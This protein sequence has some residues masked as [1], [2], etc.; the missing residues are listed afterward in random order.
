MRVIG[1]FLGAMLGAVLAG[2]AARAQCTGQQ[3]AI[4][5]QLNLACI[6]TDRN[7]VLDAADC[8]LRGFADVEQAD[9][10]VIADL[11]FVALQGSSPTKIRGCQAEQFVGDGNVDTSEGGGFV[12]FDNATTGPFF[13]SLLGAAVAALPVDVA[14][15][16]AEDAD[17]FFTLGAGRLVRDA[18]GTALDVTL[19]N[20]M[21]LRLGVSERRS[22]NTDLRCL[23]VPFPT[24]NGVLPLEMF[25]LCIPVDANGDAVV[26][27]ADDP[28]E[29]FVRL[30]FGAAAG[31]AAAP[32]LTRIGLC[33]ALAVLLAVGTVAMRR[34]RRFA[35]VLRDI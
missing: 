13:V 1:A 32:A 5:G 4:A 6:D 28:T 9:G 10:P 15:A 2:D 19:Q 7:G 18:T 26:T 17:D 16:R 27:F 35:A 31:A 29:R 23:S 30:R 24:L 8:C 12:Q 11:C 14:E 34:S 25:D 22:G 3:L 21:T 20:L 33:L